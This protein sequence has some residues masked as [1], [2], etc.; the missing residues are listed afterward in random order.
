MRAVSQVPR[1]LEIAWARGVRTLA[2]L[3]ALSLFG[4]GA[5][6]E[7]SCEVDGG[8]GNRG[9][10]SLGT[11]TFP[12]PVCICAE[13]TVRN[14][15][16]G[17]VCLPGLQL[18][19]NGISVPVADE[20]GVQLL[21]QIPTEAPTFEIEVTGGLPQFIGTINGVRGLK[22]SEPRMEPMKTFVI[23]LEDGFS[24]V[25]R[26]VN[27]LVQSRPGFR[28]T[29]SPSAR[30]AFTGTTMTA[31]GQVVFG[32]AQRLGGVSGLITGHA[33]SD[34][35]WQDGG[36]LNVSTLL[37]STVSV[38]D[39][40]SVL[41]ASGDGALLH[42]Y[43]L[44]PAGW[45]KQT[46]SPGMTASGVHVANSREVWV[47]RAA[48][49]GGPFSLVSDGGS[50]VVGT[51]LDT[52]GHVIASTPDSRIVAVGIPNSNKVEI[53][54]DDPTGRRLR[55]VVVGTAA[56]FGAAVALSGDG[57]VLVVGTSGFPQS[58]RIYERRDGG[59]VLQREVNAPLEPRRSV[60]S[61][62]S[63]YPQVA[64]SADGLTA[65]LAF[66]ND[67]SVVIAAREVAGWS[68]REAL[69]P[70]PYDRTGGRFGSGV[71]LSANGNRLSVACQSCVTQPTL[72]VYDRH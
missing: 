28:G 40:G 63:M 33:A 36:V 37:G 34:A 20:L 54:P 42:L 57:S 38:S 71:A 3:A 13:G 66:P 30:D 59:Y 31:D 50:W 14:T 65:A 53:Y 16:R 25:T 24:L 43:R 47:A 39:D 27:V 19:V 52:I 2:V 8:C 5:A 64:V 4:C 46:L 15:F 45:K 21:V 67:N 48:L 60:A 6:S 70:Q 61:V 23:T 32:V 29:E 41:S 62:L 10:C 22:I 9:S 17:P 7:P 51:R 1:G 69:V 56:G 18:S 49:D 68:L 26:Q 72:S 11:G 12:V 35:G 44:G 58:A 55:E